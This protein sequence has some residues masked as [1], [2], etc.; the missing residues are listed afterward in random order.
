MRNEL[1]NL[2]FKYRNTFFSDDKPLGS[3]S[4]HE[5]DLKLNIEIPFS[6]VLRKTA[7]PASLRDREALE[8]STKELVELRFLRKV[9]YNGTVEVAN[10][11]IIE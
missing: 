2:L 7:Y 9:G 8:K 10:P 4:R 1:N 5:V 3:I 11:F 6:P